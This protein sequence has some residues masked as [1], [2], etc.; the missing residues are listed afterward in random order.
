MQAYQGEG[1]NINDT[2][3]LLDIIAPLQP[4]KNRATEIL[5]GDAYS[6]DVR[7]AQQQ[8]TQAGIT[9]VPSIV[10]NR[11]HLLQGAQAPETYVQ[12]L[13]E[14]AAKSS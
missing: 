5:A 14:L 9:A 7:R 13:R 1:K 10:I 3:V 2:S 12:A 6:S 8:W 4:D 11:Q